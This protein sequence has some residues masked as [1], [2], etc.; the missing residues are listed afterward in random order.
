MHDYATI[1]MFINLNDIQKS[2]PY[3]IVGEKNQK[4]RT[5]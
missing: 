1:K 3:S 5:E 2:S 4:Q